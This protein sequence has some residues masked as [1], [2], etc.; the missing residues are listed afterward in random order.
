MLILVNV[1]ESMST[2]LSVTAT[3]NEL[4]VP[5]V[6][7]RMLEEYCEVMAVDMGLLGGGPRRERLS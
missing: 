5:Q 2:L 7:E 6:V 3:K 1:S 4:T